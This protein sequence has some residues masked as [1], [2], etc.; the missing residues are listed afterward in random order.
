MTGT[1]VFVS[2]KNGA[3]V[4]TADSAAAIAVRSGSTRDWLNIQPL[5]LARARLA[6]RPGLRVAAAPK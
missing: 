4:L 1:N 2:Y 5:M 3:A 6:A